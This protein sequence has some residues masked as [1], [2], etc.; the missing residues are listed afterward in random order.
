MKDM[1]TKIGITPSGAPFRISCL[2]TFLYICAIAEKN[3]IN[4]E[5]SK[6]IFQIDDTNTAKRKYTNEEIIDF[7]KKMG[8]I[9]FKHSTYDITIQTN[10]EEECKKYFEILESKNLIIYNSDNTASFDIKKYMSIYG[11]EIE[12]NDK[13]SGKIIF[14]ANNITDEDSIIIRRSDG[15]FLYNFSAAVDT[16]HWKFT[17]LIRGINKISSAAFQ[18]MYIKALDFTPPEYYHLPLLIAEKNENNLGIN[19]KSDIREIFNNGFSYMPVLTYL[20]NTGYGEQTDTYDSLEDFYKKFEIEKLHKTNACFDY[21]IMKKTCSRYYQHEMTYEDYYDQLEKHIILMSW[22]KEIIKYSKIGYK[23]NLNP[24]K[25]KQLYEEM[26]KEHFDEI[27]DPNEIEKINNLIN[28]L[29]YSY[30]ET[31]EKILADKATKKENIKLV[32]YILSGYQDG[33]MCNVYK[34]CYTEEEYQ[35]R[36]LY[37][38]KNIEKM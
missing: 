15:S 18:N 12:V 22:D 4:G 5:N 17:T 19:F 3:S 1:V 2:R 7:Y 27:N 9:P 6:I 10:L 34:E 23:Y 25:V 31:I 32:K 24:E 8:I 20:L 16:I 14:D 21:N 38:K 37:V 11:N 35:K 28:S 36:L 33:L 26:N 30:E 13:V 29:L